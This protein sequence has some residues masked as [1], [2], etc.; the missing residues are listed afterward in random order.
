MER[1]RFNVQTAPWRSGCGAWVERWSDLRS[2]LRMFAAR[3]AWRRRPAA[4]RRTLHFSEFW[5]V[6]PSN[7]I[8]VYILRD[9]YAILPPG[10][11]TLKP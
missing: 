9:V 10:S 8:S 11:G 6:F 5:G 2:M 7:W 1:R 4:A 3:G